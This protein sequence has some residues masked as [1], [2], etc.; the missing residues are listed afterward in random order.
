M[1][2][3]I[4]NTIASIMMLLAVPNVYAAPAQQAGSQAAAAPAPAGGL[5]GKLLSDHV[6][7]VSEPGS[8]AATPDQSNPILN[9]HRD[10]H[11]AIDGGVSAIAGGLGGGLAPGA[12][13]SSAF[14]E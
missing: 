13:A 3:N 9:V 10:A 8:A 14:K 12:A 6:K 2:V 5:I 7:F 4:A 11:A 1:Y